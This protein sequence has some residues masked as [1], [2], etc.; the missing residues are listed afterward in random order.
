[1]TRYIK[2]FRLMVISALVFFLLLTGI[3]VFVP[4]HVRISRATNL[5]PGTEGILQQVADLGQWKNWHPLFDH[6]TYKNVEMDK[7][8][9]VSASTDSVSV[10]IVNS[11]DSL[12]AVEMQRGKRT[13]YAT[14][15]LIRYA[16]SDSLTL[17]NYMDFK[18]KW[19]PWDKFSSLLLEPSFGPVMEKG[20]IRLKTIADRSEPAT[21]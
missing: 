11:N 12:V 21:H 7:G 19:Y 17:Q 16:T 1:M 3:S 20:L 14:W 4:S 8:R 6:L 5:A 13:V 10:T 15:K 2:V 9:I 18:F